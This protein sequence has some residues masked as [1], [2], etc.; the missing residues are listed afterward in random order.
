MFPGARSVQQLVNINVPTGYLAQILKSNA[1]AD[2]I[3]QFGFILLDEAHMRTIDYDIVFFLMK[4]FIS[5][6]LTNPNC[7][8][9]I[10]MSA[11]FPINKYAR[12]F[13]VDKFEIMYVPGQT[14]PKEEHF[15][16]FPY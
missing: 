12:Y 14:Y 6:N 13:G 8:F 16:D 3:S 1:D 10:M 5:R 2:I 4:R 11:T 15:A 9:L 7:P